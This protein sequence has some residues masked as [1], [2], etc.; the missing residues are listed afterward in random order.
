MN[1]E[2][3]V[4]IDNFEGPLDLMVHLIKENK[5]DLFNLDILV[6]ATQYIEYIKLMEEMDLEIAGEYLVILADLI[7][8]KT[9]KLLP[10]ETAEL[11]DNY[12]G[13]DPETLVA[14]IIEYKRYKEVSSELARLNEEREKLLS[15]PVSSLIDKWASEA[16]VVLEPMAIYSLVN[17]MDK[18]Q[19]RLSLLEPLKLKKTEK[20]LTIEDRTKDIRVMIKALPTTFSFEDLCKDATTKIVVILTFLSILEMLKKE[21]LNYFLQSDILY[22]QKG[23]GYVE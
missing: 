8:Y 4:S 9:K 15:K 14:R 22:F 6:L 2:L 21:E 1:K 16:E 10:K 13:V 5:L 7:E 19:K 17:A 3:I 12:Q 11:S 23:V 20:E 18:V